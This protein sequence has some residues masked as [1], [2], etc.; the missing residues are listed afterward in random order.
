MEK[1]IADMT[2]EELHREWMAGIRL[3]Q[4]CGLTLHEAAR[5]AEIER[6]VDRRPPVP[7]DD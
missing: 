4:E 5:L 7:A 1:Q 3:E 6:E 2:D